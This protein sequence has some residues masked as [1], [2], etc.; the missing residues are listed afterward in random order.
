MIKIYN[1]LTQNWHT[2]DKRSEKFHAYSCGVTV[3]DHCHLGHGRVFVVQDVLYRFLRDRGYNPYFIRNITDVDDKILKKA[4]ALTCDPRLVTEEYTRSMHHDLLNLNCLAPD[5]EPRA[6][7]YISKM[8]SMIEMMLSKGHAYISEDDV[9]FSVHSFEK[10]GQLSHQNLEQLNAGARVQ[11]DELKQHHCDFVLWKKVYDDS[12]SWDSPWGKGRPGW[13]IE[14]SAMISGHCSHSLDLHI[15]GM[16]LKFPHHENEIAQSESCFHHPLAQCWMH[17]G[18]VTVDDEKMAKSLGNFTYLA[19]ALKALSSQ[20]LRYLYLMTHYR[21]PLPWTEQRVLQAQSAIRGFLDSIQDYY[22]FELPSQQNKDTLVW[23]ALNRSL[24]DDLN[25]P[26]AITEFQSQWALLKLYSDD[27][28]TQILSTLLQWF[29]EIL[30]INL[31]EMYR[32]LLGLESLD[33][34]LQHL[35]QERL[36]A[37]SQKDY[38]RADDLRKLIEKNGFDVVDR[39]E[40][41]FYREQI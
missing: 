29:N 39:K 37:K 21:Q 13:H 32:P 3:Y 23:E 22:P 10:Y 2:F 8:I 38:Q 12:L 6:T 4:Q 35:A 41:T 17:I 11:T 25:T 28:R 18:F 24:A 1:S 14:C 7:E 20:T 16:D 5:S 40:G 33:P 31:K 27:R 34:A 15:G 30:G 9:L 36:V 19:D 26:L